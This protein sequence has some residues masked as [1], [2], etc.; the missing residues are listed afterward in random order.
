MGKIPRFK[1]VLAC[2]TIIWTNVNSLSCFPRAFFFP[3]F[4]RNIETGRLK[5]LTEKKFRKY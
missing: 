1:Q 3:N 5:N 2:T 4:S